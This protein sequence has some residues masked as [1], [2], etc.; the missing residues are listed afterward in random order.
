MSAFAT[1]KLYHTDT[2]PLHYRKGDVIFDAGEE[3]DEMY[4]ILE[5]SVGLWVDGQLAEVIQAGDVFGEGALVQ[6]SHTRGS[7]AIAQTDCQLLSLN[8]SRFL[9]VCQSTPMFA[10][11]VM[12]SFSTRLRTLKQKIAQGK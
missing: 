3:G 6:I 5:G 12:R 9:F 10:I 11:E 4:A 7:R 1:I 2:E 8:Q